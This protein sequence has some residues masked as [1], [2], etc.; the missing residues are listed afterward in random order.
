MRRKLLTKTFATS[1][2]HPS[3]SFQSLIGTFCLTLNSRKPSS[4]ITLNLLKVKHAAEE[5][6]RRAQSHKKNVKI[7]NPILI[8]ILL[9]P[10][11]FHSPKFRPSTFCWLVHCLCCSLSKPFLCGRKRA[12]TSFA[13]NVRPE[14]FVS[15]EPSCMRVCLF[16]KRDHYQK[17]CPRMEHGSGENTIKA[18][19]NYL[20]FGLSIAHTHTHARGLFT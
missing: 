18:V 17:V 2:G 11:R 13:N 8:S 6:K 5:R 1:N 7:I 10:A 20:L 19:L 9:P 3:L 12:L 16:V 14:T 4:Q 15:T